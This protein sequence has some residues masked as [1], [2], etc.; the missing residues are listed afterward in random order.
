MYDLAKAVTEFRSEVKRKK[1]YM[2]HGRLKEERTRIM[3]AEHVEEGYTEVKFSYYGEWYIMFGKC[4]LQHTLIY[5]GDLK[6][7]CE[8]ARKVKAEMV[9]NYGVTLPIQ[10]VKHEPIEWI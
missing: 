4:Q 3:V 1:G 2:K 8:V 5:K 7:A 6:T 10:F 9:E